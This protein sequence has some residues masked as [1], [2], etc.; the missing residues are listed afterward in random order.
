[1]ADAAPAASKEGEAPTMKVGAEVSPTTG[2]PAEEKASEAAAAPE[3]PAGPGVASQRP[4]S[5]IVKLKA[6]ANAPVL[7]EK[8]RKFKLPASNPL[9][10]VVNHVEQLLKEKVQGGTRIVRCTLLHDTHPTLCVD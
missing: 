7:V 8:K 6:A 9:T 3:T 4:D 1:M 5:V 2:A 10:R